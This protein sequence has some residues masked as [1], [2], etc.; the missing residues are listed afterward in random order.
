[1]N[2]L[3]KKTTIVWLT[4]CGAMMEKIEIAEQKK[5]NTNVN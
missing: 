4:G 3:M 2:R 5:M 1:M